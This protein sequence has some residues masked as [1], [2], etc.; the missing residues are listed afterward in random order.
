M[1]KM[2][3]ETGKA[4]AH[5]A[6]VRDSI[7]P[8]PNNP[9]A[10]TRNNYGRQVAA[11]MGRHIDIAW[12]SPLAW[13]DSQRQSGGAC[14]AT[15]MRD[16]DR[17]RVPHLVV[18]QA[19]ASPG[20]RTCAAGPL[21]PLGLLGCHGLEPQTNSNRNSSMFWL[22]CRATMSAGNWCTTSPADRRRDVLAQ[23]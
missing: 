15:A 2:R 14:R 18:E 21:I 23:T 16:T 20:S 8:G 4:R 1:A 19:T 11:L 5:L 3:I 17:N 6:A 13:L 12:R 7:E 22:V 10:G 9:L